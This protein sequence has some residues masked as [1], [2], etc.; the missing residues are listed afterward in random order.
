MFGLTQLGVVHTIISLIAVAAGVVAFVRYGSISM[1]TRT[2]QT[3][4][5]MTVLTCLTG[6][7]IFQQGGFG[8]PHAVGV[9]E[10]VLL[11]FAVGL[12]KRVFLGAMSRAIETVTYT[13]TFFLH[14]IPA[15][16]ETTTRLPPAAPLAAGPED[17]LVL[18]LVGAAFAG[19]VIGAVY[20]VARLRAAAA[21]A[22][23][24]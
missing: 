7:P 24:R 11:A 13:A 15:V 2:G 22:R 5:V 1:R 12:E 8:P 19:F 4:V 20:Q 3:Y 16:N 18:A 14:M 23:A 9:L 17:P 10:L 21:P 6:F